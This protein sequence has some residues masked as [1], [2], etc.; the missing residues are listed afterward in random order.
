M[1][2]KIQRRLMFSA[3]ADL[4]HLSRSHIEWYEE[5]EESKMDFTSAV[6]N[7]HQ[8]RLFQSLR[9]V[10]INVCPA[11]KN[12]TLIVFAPNLK[13]VMSTKLLRYGRSKSVLT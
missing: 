12:L 10:L 8:P 7:V 5:L 3:L 4:K 11:L 1:A 13:S 6:Q 2:S 9:T